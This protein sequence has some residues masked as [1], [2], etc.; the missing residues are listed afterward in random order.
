MKD[1]KSLKLV[2]NIK[3]RNARP[4][5]DESTRIAV[6][7]HM[8][9]CTVCGSSD[10]EYLTWMHEC[11]YLCERCYKAIEC[12]HPELLYRPEEIAEGNAAR[13]VTKAKKD[14]TLA[15]LAVKDAER[16][17]ETAKINQRVFEA[18]RA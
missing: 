8:E 12:S 9:A 3:Q 16:S 13:M 1:P 17:Y 10:L 18:A 4:K 14:L 6:D 5:I 2:K 15:A 11:G 7:Y